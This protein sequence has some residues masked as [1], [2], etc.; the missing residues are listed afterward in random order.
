MYGVL[1]YIATHRIPIRAGWIY[2]PPLPVTAALEK[3]LGMPS[4]AVETQIEGV[5][6]AIPAAVENKKDNT[7]PV[8]SLW[9]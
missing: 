6:A 9:Q 8:R 5:K 2:L 3:N 1:H 7:E 4:M